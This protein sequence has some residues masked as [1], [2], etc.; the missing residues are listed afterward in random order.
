[1]SDWWTGVDGEAGED[2]VSAAAGE[3]RRPAVADT[4]STGQAARSAAARETRAARDVPAG[5]VEGLRQQRRGGRRVAGEGR[6][7][8]AE[9]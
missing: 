3:H 9:S 7:T 4:T 8:A 2:A 5:Q 1:M 6:G